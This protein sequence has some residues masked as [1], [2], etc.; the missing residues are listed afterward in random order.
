M[1]KDSVLLN[2]TSGGDDINGS[3]HDFNI[4]FSNLGL[5]HDA[6]TT[7]EIAL[8]SYSMWY[9]WYN[10]STVLGNNLFKYNN[11]VTD[12]ILT[13]PN[14]QYGVSDLNALIKNQ[15]LAL[16]DDP[17]SITISGNYNTLKVDIV[18][19]GSYSVTFDGS[20]L[21]NLLGF[22]EGIFIAGTWSSQNQPD[23]TNGIDAVQIHTSLI[24][25]KSNLINNTQSTCI[26]Q[27]TPQSGPG[28]NLSATISYPIYLQ[29]NNAGNVHF[30][31]FSVKDNLGR[32]LDLNG[33]Q[34]SFVFHIRS[35]T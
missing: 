15:I 25:P 1:N 6:N 22:T 26:H 7:H 8:I 16:S 18:I 13:L 29:M 21:Q 2:I 31:S 34:T 14:G 10:V 30:S 33:E 24:S 11:G 23:I 20:G 12:R 28:S 5:I 27:F 32:S 9:S 35:V 4:N 17:D 19:T 3:S